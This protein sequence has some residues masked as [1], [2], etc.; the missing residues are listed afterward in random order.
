MT[1]LSFAACDCIRHDKEALWADIL[2]RSFDSASVPPSHK[3]M[4]DRLLRRDR[5]ND[6]FTAPSLSRLCYLGNRKGLPLQF[7]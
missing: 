3:A 6:F 2:N 1:V 4:V 5:Q 7:N